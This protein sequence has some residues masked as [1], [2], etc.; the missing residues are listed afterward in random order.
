MDFV[1]NSS[2]ASFILSILSHVAYD[3]EGFKE[4]VL[5]PL[6]ADFKSEY[7]YSNRKVDSGYLFPKEIRRLDDNHFEIED[8]TSMFNSFDD[9]TVFFEYLMIQHFLGSLKKVYYCEIES[10]RVE[11]NQG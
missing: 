2:S 11:R 6:I 10:F 5:E 1:T 3:E 9:M 7:T 8:W 4:K